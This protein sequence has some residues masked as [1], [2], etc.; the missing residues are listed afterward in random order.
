MGSLRLVERLFTEQEA[1]ELLPQLRELLER[2]RQAKEA[3]ASGA[4]AS[5]TRVAS[6]GTAAAAATGSAAEREFSGVLAEIEALGVV[7]R[8]PDSGLVDFA[9]SR[10][11]EPIY[12]CWRLG[13][14]RVG[15]WH[16]R[17]TGY[18]GREPL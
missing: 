9:A 2:L 4:A 5:V 18:A 1:N 10:G 14:D 15:Y 12:L 16:P 8:D 17:D 13:E 11:G 7:V 3:L 6:N